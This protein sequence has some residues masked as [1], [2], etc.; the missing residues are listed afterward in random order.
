LVKL[1]ARMRQDILALTKGAVDLDDRSTYLKWADSLILHNML[2]QHSGAGHIS[3]CWKLRTNKRIMRVFARLFGCSKKSLLVSFDGFSVHFAPEDTLTKTGKARGFF[4][5]GS[6]W[7]HTDQGPEG[8]PAGHCTDIAQGLVSLY[9]ATSQD[10]TLVVLTESHKHWRE[11][12]TAFPDVAPGN[13]AKENWHKLTKP[14][15]LAF[16]EARGCK[17]LAVPMSAGSLV[18][19]N[20]RTMHCGRE[21]LVGRPVPK[22]R[23]VGYV[24]YTPLPGCKR[25]GTKQFGDDTSFYGDGT[26]APKVLEQ[27]AAKVLMYKQ[28]K[29]TRHTPFPA[30]AFPDKPH[31]YGRPMPDLATPEVTPIEQLPRWQRRLIGLRRG[32]A[33]YLVKAE[34]AAEKRKA[35]AEKRRVAAAEKKRL[36]AA[37]AA[38]AATEAPV[39]TDDADVNDTD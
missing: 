34:A 4:K 21:P 17:E 14:E 15:H 36:A 16:F 26:I 18:L 35:G 27:L 3:M 8:I 9:D 10:A 6:L 7:L 38:A 25:K 28:R 32:V 19:W 33:P 1:R 29:T 31:T 24:C 30:K 39:A 20:S 37:A 11:F 23:I 22:N 2:L 5:E 13:K 12:F